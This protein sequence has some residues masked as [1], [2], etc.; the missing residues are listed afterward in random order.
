MFPTE[1]ALEDYVRSDDY[2]NRPKIYA[3]VV[4][5]DEGHGVGAAAYKL[6]VNHSSVPDTSEM[7]APFERFGDTGPQW[8]YQSWFPPR[9]RLSRSGAGDFQDDEVWQLVPS[10]LSLQ[11]LVDNFFLNVTAQG[12]PSANHVEAIWRELHDPARR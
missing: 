3:A 6:R 5:G 10:F 9:Y 12:E 8:S 11:L 2:E 7:T 1:A 4:F